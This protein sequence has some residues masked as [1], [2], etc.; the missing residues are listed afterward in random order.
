MW[1]H[2][3]LSGALQGL[4]GVV[5]GRLDRCEEP[6]ADFT[7][8]EVMADLLMELGVPSAMGL[9]IGHAGD[10]FAVLLGATAVLD[11][12]RGTLENG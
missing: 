1:T 8:A 5:V 3:R 7:A 2:L 11:A 9:P 4:A 6:N 10:N 12:T